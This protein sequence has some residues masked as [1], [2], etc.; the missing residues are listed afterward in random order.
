MV[1]IARNTLDICAICT[2]VSSVFFVIIHNEG[3]CGTMSVK[4][5]TNI[6]DLLKKA[7]YNTNRLRKEKL[8][9]EATIQK[10]RNNELVSWKNI[11]AICMLIGCQVGDL[12]EYEEDQ[13]L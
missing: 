4:Y 10:L 1:K 8:L 5:K 13:P 12:L 11:D 9:G 2:L 6:L 3:W 7:G